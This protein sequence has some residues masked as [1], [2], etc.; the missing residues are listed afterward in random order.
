MIYWLPNIGK[1]QFWWVIPEQNI[2]NFP[3]FFIDRNF[4]KLDLKISWSNRKNKIDAIFFAHAI[5]GLS[6]IGKIT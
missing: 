6:N 1:I 4:F 2:S 5:Y 3:L